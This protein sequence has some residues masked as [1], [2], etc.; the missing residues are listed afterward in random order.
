M[1][2]CGWMFTCHL[3]AALF[4]ATDPK[5]DHLFC[6]CLKPVPGA[7][8]VTPCK[9]APQ[10][11]RLRSPPRASVYLVGPAALQGRAQ[12]SRPRGSAGPTAVPTVRA[13]Y[14]RT[15]REPGAQPRAGKAFPGS[16]SARAKWG[17]GPR[18][19]SSRTEGETPNPTTPSPPPLQGLPSVQKAWVGPEPRRDLPVV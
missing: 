15:T 19:P 3:F 16:P 12:F 4:P 17:H 9:V 1:A 18:P 13:L 10:A 8:P 6:P 5:T 2:S 14:P 7:V 11:G